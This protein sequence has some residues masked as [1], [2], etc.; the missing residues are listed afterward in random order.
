M[1][2]LGSLMKLALAFS[3]ALLAMTSCL[4]SG[5]G[6]KK[7]DSNNPPSVI[8]PLDSPATPAR[9]YFKGSLPNAPSGMDLGEAY[10]NAA[11]Y[12]EFVPVWG[13]PTPFYDLGKDLAGGYGALWV[14][15]LVRENGMFPLI[16]MSFM[17]TGVTLKAPPGMAGATLASTEWRE[18]YKEA[19][20]DVVRASRPKYLS[21]GNEVNRWYEEYGAE[22]GD[23]NGFQNWVSLYNEVYDAVKELS[24]Q[25]KVFCTFAREMVDELREADLKVLTMFD[26]SKL[27]LLVF[28]SYPYSVRKDRTGALL[29]APF[30]RPADIPDDY[31][32]R[33]LTYMPGKPLGFSEIAWTS[34]AFYGGELSQADFLTH[35][36]GRLTADQGIDLE[37]MGWCWLYDLSPDQPIGLITSDG[38]EKAAYAVWKGL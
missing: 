12:M 19:A 3:A 32:S 34:A 5:C 30:N 13:R 17:E 4:L 38:T 9:G 29:A 22:T 10:A 35:L 37:L 36:V 25:T 15:Q 16:H 2:R 6:P 21:L 26:P 1:S 18:A 8:E 11:Q 23:D 33:A 31:Y 28:T 20:L 27:D 14:Q 7:E 24:P